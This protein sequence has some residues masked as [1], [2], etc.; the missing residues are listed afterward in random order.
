MPIKVH[1]HLKTP[2]QLVL[3]VWRPLFLEDVHDNDYVHVYTGHL[4]KHEYIVSSTLFILLTINVM[5]LTCS[6]S[7]NYIR[8]DGVKVLVEAL[9]VN[10]KDVKDIK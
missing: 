10:C 6:L 9:L 7:Y 3:L 1:T 8:D 4:I 2:L 5:I